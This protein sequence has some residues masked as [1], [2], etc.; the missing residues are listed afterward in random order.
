M[1]WQHLNCHLCQLDCCSRVGGCNWI[2]N[3][4]EKSFVIHLKWVTTY[5]DTEI[6]GKKKFCGAFLAQK[7]NFQG[8]FPVFFNLYFASHVTFLMFFFICIGFWKLHQLSSTSETSFNIF[9]STVWCVLCSI[10]KSCFIMCN[11]M[12]C[13]TPGFPVLHHLPEFAQIYV[14]LVSD[15]I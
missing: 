13:S 11:P 6:G 2:I 4:W 8:K 15:A 14:H 9:C 7:I 12:D 3:S 1:T 10:T 5:A